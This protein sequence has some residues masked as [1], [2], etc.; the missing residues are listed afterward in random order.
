MALHN[1]LMQWVRVLKL[2]HRGPSWPKK[3][4]NAKMAYSHFSLHSLQ[5]CTEHSSARTEDQNLYTCSFQKVPAGSLLSPYSMTI[6]LF[7][8]SN[9]TLLKHAKKTTNFR[10]HQQGLHANA[11]HVRAL[12]ESTPPLLHYVDEPLVTQV[13]KFRIIQ[14]QSPLPYYTGTAAPMWLYRCSVS[15]EDTSMLMGERSHTSE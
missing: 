14:G 9:N 11:Q 4:G 5:F 8:V 15:G 6:M 1:P 13:N 12:L 10:V 7:S 3:G 2:V